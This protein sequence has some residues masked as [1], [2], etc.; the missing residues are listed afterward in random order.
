MPE[1]VADK[2][3]KS[4]IPAV[5]SGVHKAALWLLSVEQEL[6]VEVLAHL[7]EE[8]IRR[9]KE[10]VRKLGRPTPQELARVHD[11]FQSKLG[12]GQYQPLQLRGSM[13]Y[14][15]DLTT[16][17]LGAAK[18]EKILSTEADTGTGVNLSKA[19]VDMVAALLSEQHPQIIAAVLANVDPYRGSEILNRIPDEIR[20]EVVTR[21]ATLSRVPREALAQ[22]ERVLSAGLTV[23]T[24]E[25]AGLN[26]ISIAASLL[27]QLDP[28]Y[29]A[30]VLEGM[31]ATSE[32]MVT[33]IRRAMFTFEDL[34]KIDRRGLQTL[35][36]EVDSDQLL[37]ALKTASIQLKEKV[38]ASLSKRA[39]EMLREDLEVMGSVRLS[40]VETAQQSIVETALRLRSEGR[41]AIAG[42][43]EDYV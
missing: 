38:L 26:G 35:L 5:M 25:E 11:E 12:E 6:A 34:V 16:K 33:R 19:N 3:K 14:L 20:K 24:D 10:E 39:A 4:S 31:S 32:E 43:G 7:D 40:D 17:A 22:A 2:E 37:I 9:L 42:Q 36:R 13:D 15:A 21:V 1:V 30:E 41:L 23:T 29:A 8:D 28:E 27:N 18:A